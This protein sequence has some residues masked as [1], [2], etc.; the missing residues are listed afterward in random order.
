LREAGIVDL[1]ET[2]VVS[3]AV[4]WRKPA[5]TIFRQTLDRMGLEAGEA[6]FVGDRAD[7]D[8]AGARAMGMDAAWLNPAAEPLPPGLAP[9]TYELRD[10][11][12][13]R[14]ILVKSDPASDGPPHASHQ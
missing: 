10:L 7:I 2:I 4:G 9:P 8:V 13:L 11:A 6:L 5:P 14:A 12:D 3:D 1:F